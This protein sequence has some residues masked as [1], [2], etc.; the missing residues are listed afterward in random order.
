MEHNHHHHH[1]H[2]ESITGDLKKA[3]ICAIVLTALFIAFEAWMGLRSDA[4]SLVS[5]AGHKLVD[6]LSMGLTLLAFYLSSSKPAGKFTF[7]YR[8][9][10]VIISLFNALFVMAVSGTIIYESIEKMSDPAALSPDPEVISLTA[11]VGIV[12]NFLIVALLSYHRR[13]DVNTR[14][15]FLHALTDCLLSFGVV[16]GGFIIKWTGFVMLDPIISLCIAGFIIANMFSVLVESL[17]LSIDAV[18]ENVDMTKVESDL[19]STP[20]VRNIDRLHVWPVSTTETAL[21]AVV[22]VDGDSDRDEVASR[23]RDILKADGISETTLETRVFSNP[24]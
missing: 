15:A 3:Y 13:H 24:E 22:T 5:D 6:L 23:L 2:A 11:G 1:H 7:G 4:M 20:G 9:L 21:T 8:K 18:P 14:G 10:T 19:L 12:V 16:I 17:R